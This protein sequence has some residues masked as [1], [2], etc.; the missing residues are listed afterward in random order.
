M[1]SKKPTFYLLITGFFL[2]FACSKNEPT[3][4]I[5]TVPI[6]QTPALNLPIEGNQ[7]ANCLLMSWGKVESAENYTVQIGTDVVFSL[8]GSRILEEKL[9]SSYNRY[10]MDFR[11]LESGKYYCRI[12]SGNKQGESKWSESVFFQVRLQNI[13]DCIEYDAPKTPSLQHPS[14]SVNIEDDTVIFSWTESPKATHYR[15]EVKALF[16]LPQIVYDNAEIY[17][18]TRT[19]QSFPN[20]PYYT[21][22]V[23]AYNHTAESPWSDSRVF[24]V[25]P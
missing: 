4:P 20:G 18:P 15:L 2:L 9:D 7:Y 16:S 23:K 3:P 17:E 19:V 24:R 14:D 13:A 8:N 12:K 22:R 25:E 1:K 11:D 5:S 10:I 21:W 6:P